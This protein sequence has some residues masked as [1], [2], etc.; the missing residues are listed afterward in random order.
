MVEHP[1]DL[2]VC[3]NMHSFLM[4]VYLIRV[5]YFDHLLEPL[6][7]V[8]H[9][10]FQSRVALTGYKMGIAF[11]NIAKDCDTCIQVF[12]QSSVDWM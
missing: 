5:V 12:G 9:L 4:N 10:L 2:P 7:C 11:L 8:L 6:K 1:L 3:I